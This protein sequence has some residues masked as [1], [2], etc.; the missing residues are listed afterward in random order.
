MA[1]VAIDDLDPVL[2]AG[3]IEMIQEAIAGSS[4]GGQAESKVVRLRVGEFKETDAF[5]R[6]SGQAAIY[7]GS[8]GSYLLRL[9]NLDV[10]NGPALHVYL[11]LHADP[12]SADDVKR[13]GYLGLGKLKGNRVNQNYQIPAGTDIWTFNSVVIYCKPFAV[14]F[15]VA[16][17]GDAA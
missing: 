16:T 5:H 1:S 11:S 15:S 4:N 8:G 2:M 10:T 14:V 9:E 12:E 6:R 17:L 13:P 3:G 7:S